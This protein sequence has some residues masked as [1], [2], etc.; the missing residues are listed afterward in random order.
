MYFQTL[1]DKAASER[2]GHCFTQRQW[3][4][5]RREPGLWEV[6]W[7]VIGTLA[8]ATSLSAFEAQLSHLPAMSPQA[9]YLISPC[10]KVLSVN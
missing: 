4:V 7:V 9:I 8:L 5:Y 2:V 6:V 3:A 1:S 10:L